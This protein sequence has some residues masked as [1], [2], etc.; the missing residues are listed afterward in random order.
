M[1][2]CKFRFGLLVFPLLLLSCKSTDLH[3]FL[4][5]EATENKEEIKLELDINKLQNSITQVLRFSASLSEATEIVSNSV[6]D[7]NQISLGLETEPPERAIPLHCSQTYPIPI[8]SNSLLTAYGKGFLDEQIRDSRHGYDR[9]DREISLYGEP[10]GELMESARLTYCYVTRSPS[11]IVELKSYQGQPIRFSDLDFVYRGY[12]ALLPRLKFYQEV[13]GYIQILA[14]SI[15]GGIW[16]KKDDIKDY[17]Y[18]TTWIE[19]IINASICQLGGTKKN[20]LRDQPHLTGR[21]LTDIDFLASTDHTTYAIRQ[22]TGNIKGVWAEA[23]VYEVENPEG[24]PSIEPNVE[25]IEAN[26]TER[27]WQGWI[28]LLDGEGKPTVSVNL[29]CYC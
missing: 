28:K 29:G 24:M 22:F 15:P 4:A 25:W 8:S 5:A 17:L 6:K 12:K 27:Q 16:V 19:D 14:N 21:I 23:I 9:L 18:P 2:F 13:D 20:Y 3:S 10:H 7:V 11:Y 1:Q 26:W